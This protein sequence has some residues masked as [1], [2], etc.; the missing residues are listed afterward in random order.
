[1][2]NVNM[3]ASQINYRNNTKKSVRDVGGALDR[4]FTSND[5]VVSDINDLTESVYNKADKTDIAPTF[6]AETAYFVG[7]LVY[8]SGKLW[9]FTVNHAAGEWNQEEVEVI[10][11]DTAVNELKS[12]LIN[13]VLL[14]SGASASITVSETNVLRKYKEF[15]F[16]IEG[17]I[18]NSQNTIIT[19]C[20]V[21]MLA[22]K[23]ASWENRF[24][25]FGDIVL[26]LKV[27]PG[28]IN[29]NGFTASINKSQ[30]TDW[31]YTIKAVY[32]FN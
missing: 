9:R 14:A 32:G 8:E 26:Y 1:M 25:A 21:P 30:T 2:G 28:S 23:T 13:M 24:V 20:I 11:I 16:L 19:S 12:G 31:N 27:L 7:D 15:F 18:E 4:L 3:E 10:T 5:S 29:D 22:M 6:S 17:T